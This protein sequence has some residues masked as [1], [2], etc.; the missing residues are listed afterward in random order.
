MERLR[1]FIIAVM[2]MAWVSVRLTIWLF[3]SVPFI[4]ALVIAGLLF[5]LE[6]NHLGHLLCLRETLSRKLWLSFQ[7]VM[8]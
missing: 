6:Q 7:D 1:N 4:I 5:M 3:L 2:G 8:E